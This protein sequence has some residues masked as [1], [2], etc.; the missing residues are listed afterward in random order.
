MVRRPPGSAPVQPRCA[1]TFA[2]LWLATPVPR[3]R[4]L[5][6]HSVMVRCRAT[7]VAARLRLRDE[8]VMA[9]LAANERG[10]ILTRELRHVSRDMTDGKADAPV[11]GRVR[12][13]AVNETQV[14]Q[15]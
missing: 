3:S 2:S 9:I 7:K 11:S 4:I 5:A 14:A 12:P 13:R 10:T 1:R 6:W 15:L 8:M